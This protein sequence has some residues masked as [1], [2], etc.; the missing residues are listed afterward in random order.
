MQQLHPVLK[1][2]T[3]A[4]SYFEAPM[5]GLLQGD[6]KIVTAFRLAMTRSIASWKGISRTCNGS[7]GSAQGIDEANFRS[8]RR[9][10]PNPGVNGDLRLLDVPAFVAGDAYGLF[11]GI[12]AATISGHYSSVAVVKAL[13]ASS[14]LST[15]SL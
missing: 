13:R 7:D 8:C 10:V 11:H 2:I 15:S 14:V 1:A 3:R 9:M 12:V 6:P 4:G 5:I